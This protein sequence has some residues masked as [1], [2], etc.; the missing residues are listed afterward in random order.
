MTKR[1]PNPMDHTSVLLQRLSRLGTRGDEQRVEQCASLSLE[2]MVRH[3]RSCPG[4]TSDTTPPRSND[5]RRSRSQFHR[6]PEPFHYIHLETIRD[7]DRNPP[8]HDQRLLWHEIHLRESDGPPPVA[9]PL[10]LWGRVTSDV[11]R[12]HLG[13]LVVDLVELGN[14]ILVDERIVA[15]TKLERNGVDQVLLLHRREGV[16]EEL[17]LAK[18]FL[19]LWSASAEFHAMQLL[20]ILLVSPLIRIGGRD[21]IEPIRPVVHTAFGNP[22]LVLAVSDVIENRAYRPVYRKL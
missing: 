5:E 14:G 10:R 7:K 2:M 8:R 12:D 15:V 16:V 3:D 1:L 11:D 22:R 19:E 6:S 17:R 21:R 4:R 20:R 9:L 18:V 13:Q